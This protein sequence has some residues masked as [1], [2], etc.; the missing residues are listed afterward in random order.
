ME[1]L[2]ILV[3][4]VRTRRIL[5]LH[6]Y[7]LCVVVLSAMLAIFKLHRG[8]YRNRKLFEAIIGIY[9]K[10]RY[11]WYVVQIAYLYEM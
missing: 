10:P 4:I 1:I 8:G 11:L 3:S 2:S 9:H 6:K 5:S 7:G